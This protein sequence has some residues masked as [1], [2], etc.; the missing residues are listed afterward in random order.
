MRRRPRFVWMW[1]VL[2]MVAGLPLAMAEAAE[3]YVITIRNHQF[4][5]AEL[6]VPA[7]T[8]IHLI[9]TNADKTPEEF[10]SEDFNREKMIR[11]GQTVTIRVPA[12]KPGTYEFFGEFHPKTA[13]GRLI[14]K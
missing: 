8:K 11:P 4:E 7:G 14:V 12:L 9:V 3:E 2:S 1:I 10:E 5:P 13:L 6:T